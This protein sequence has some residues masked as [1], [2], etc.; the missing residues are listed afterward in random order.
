M[1][2]GVFA[3]TI[4][5]LNRDSLGYLAQ[6][7]NTRISTLDHEGES[8]HPGQAPPETAVAAQGPAQGVGA[9]AGNPARIPRQRVWEREFL[10]D[11]PSVRTWGQLSAAERTK[12]SGMARF[13]SVCSGVIGRMRR[14]GI[15]DAEVARFL[16][17]ADASTE[18]RDA[19][20][21]KLKQLFADDGDPS[22]DIHAL[23]TDPSIPPAGGDEDM[24]DSPAGLDPS[25]GETAPEAPSNVRKLPN[26]KG[27]SKKARTTNQ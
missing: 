24:G 21:E 22:M 20:S 18:G 1:E 14:L 12:D 16:A 9:Q 26:I 11:L 5:S 8:S 23:D 13:I 10:R 17:Q 3:G 27:S 2:N 15:Q 25:A 7:I 4:M 19:V 6:L